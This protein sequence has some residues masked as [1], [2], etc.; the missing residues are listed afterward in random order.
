MDIVNELSKKDLISIVANGNTFKEW[1]KKK[2][3]PLKN[4]MDNIMHLACDAYIQKFPVPDYILSTFKSNKASAIN[5]ALKGVLFNGFSGYDKNLRH[6]FEPIALF[7]HEEECELNPGTDG[8]MHGYMH[9]KFL[10]GFKNNKEKKSL[11]DSIFKNLI[12]GKGETWYEMFGTAIL[13]LEGDYDDFSTSIIYGSANMA[14]HSKESRDSLLEI[15]P[16][17]GKTKDFE[18]IFHM[19]ITEYFAMQA[20]ACPIDEYLKDKSKSYSRYIKD[21][22]CFSMT[23]ESSTNKTSRKS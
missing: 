2:L 22:G 13:D 20:L 18:N 7:N 12:Q 19:L 11:K 8:F 3:S 23:I 4:G 17:P 14:V 15:K 16:L 9:H 6:M 1:A 21:N 10:L 5:D